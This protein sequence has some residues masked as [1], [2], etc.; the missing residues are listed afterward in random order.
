[1]GAECVGRAASLAL[2]ALWRL[3]V[4]GN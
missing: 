1:V 3:E 2:A 4:D